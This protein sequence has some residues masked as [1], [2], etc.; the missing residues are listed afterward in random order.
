MTGLAAVLMAGVAM[1]G[2]SVNATLKASNQCA[3]ETGVKI[4]AD[5]LVLKA[6]G[7]AVPVLDVNEQSGWIVWVEANVPAGSSV[8]WTP[9]KR[10]YCKKSTMSLTTGKTRACRT[11]SSKSD[12]DVMVCEGTWTVKITNGGETLA[13][14][15]FEVKS[16]EPASK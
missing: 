14:L 4:P 3:C 9:P 1:A 8:T 6:E 5:A 10:S 15:K 12:E 11:V 2:P 7:S 16:T 13:T